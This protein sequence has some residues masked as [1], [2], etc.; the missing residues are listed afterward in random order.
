MWQRLFAL[1]K[2]E[3]LVVLRD[4]KSR[5]MLIGPP[6][7]QLILFSY[8]ATLDVTNIDIAVL[9]RDSGRWSHEF[10][11]RVQGAPAF[12]SIVP[13]RL[14]TYTGLVV[15]VL[16][17]LAIVVYGVGRDHISTHVNRMVETAKQ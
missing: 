17:F 12:H 8:A 1:I 10:I 9:N 3:L 16:T 14:A 13:L 11:S 5:G 4:P 2:K 15:S 7:L 6:L